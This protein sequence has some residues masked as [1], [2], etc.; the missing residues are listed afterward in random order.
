[1]SGAKI[2]FVLPSGRARLLLFSRSGGQFI[3]SFGE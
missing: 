3:A 1:M 2:Y